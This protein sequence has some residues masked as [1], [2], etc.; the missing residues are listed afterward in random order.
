MRIYSEWQTEYR[1][2]QAY[3]F[4]WL[5]LGCVGLFF[6]IMSFQPTVEYL[7][8]T[9][10]FFVLWLV[11]VNMYLLGRQRFIRRASAIVNATEPTP[12]E[13]KLEV[14]GAKSAF[15]L[16][17][18]SR[19]LMDEPQERVRALN[20]E[21]EYVDAM[22]YKD[23]A[24]TEAVAIETAQ[25]GMCRLKPLLALRR[26]VFTMPWQPDEKFGQETADQ[27][28]RR[29]ISSGD[30]AQVAATGSAATAASGTA[31]VIWDHVQPMLVIPGVIAATFVVIIG[32]LMIFATV[33][34]HD[35]TPAE[36]VKAYAKTYGPSPL[37]IGGLNNATAY[38]ETSWTNGNLHYHL[39]LTDEA[40]GVKQWLKQ[41]PD[42]YFIVSWQSGNQS[43]GAIKIPFAAM[44]MQGRV[45]Q[46]TAD[47]GCDQKQYDAIYEVRNYWALSWNAEGKEAADNHSEQP[48]K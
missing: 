8:G 23:P 15:Y 10:I 30:S 16:R 22:L 4:G 41:H 2:L 36:K 37:T 25:N 3:S 19:L 17:D 42:G 47:V 39:T 5:A 7:A 24:T 6:R 21:S 45:V 28:L 26:S 33:S 32:G 14:R 9:V 29:R 18:G 12:V 34:H 1:L 40:G 20:S 46:S 43:V 31:A 38:I 35:L 44:Q 11:L 27:P 48:G 13:V